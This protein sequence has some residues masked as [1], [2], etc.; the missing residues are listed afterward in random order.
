M[1]AVAG[2]VIFDAR[3]YFTVAEITLPDLIGMPYQ[4]AATL[5]RRDGLDPVTFVEHVVNVAPDAVTSQASQAG[6]GVK[7]GRTIH[8]GVN[9][10]PAEAR[11][12]ELLGLREAAA[13]ARIDELNLPLEVVIY[14]PSDQPPGTVVA[15]EP[16]GGEKLGASEGIRLTVSSGAALAPVT[17][18]DLTGEDVD[19]AVVKLH[20]LGFNVIEKLP[21]AVS[22]SKPGAVVSISP[23]AGETVATSTPLIVQ[24]ALS[25]ATVVEVPE[26]AGLPQWRAQLA[27]SAAQLKVGAITY[28]DDPS[29]PEGVLEVRPQ[30]YTVPG[31]PILLTINGTAPASL[32]PPRQGGGDDWDQSGLTPGLTP[33]ITPDTSRPQLPG[34]IVTADGSRHVPFTFDPT[35]MGVKRLLEQPYRLQLKVADDRG[36][37]TVLDEL[38]DAGGT[39]STTVQVYGDEALLQTYIDDVFF[40]AWRP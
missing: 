3:R 13:V 18:P 8:L 5:L 39:V 30:G 15:Q 2:F 24:Y 22:F 31:T 10:P 32:F 17:I 23:A 36:E 28:V 12:P 25:A 11:L 9:T 4:Q 19:A 29:R 40:Q 21:S 26:L 33:G 16:G 34:S 35:N 1:L 7:R 38:V 37:R 27:L 14:S 6:S 20:R